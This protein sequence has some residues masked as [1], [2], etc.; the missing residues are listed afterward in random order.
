ML[1]AICATWAAECVRGFLAYERML[2]AHPELY[3]Q[4][5]FWAYL[6]P[7]RQDIDDYRAYLGHVLSVTVPL[8]ATGWDHLA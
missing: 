8:E 2:A 5:L 4:V 7:S 1:A 3:G 6:Q